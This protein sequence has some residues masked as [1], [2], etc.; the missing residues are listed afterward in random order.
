MAGL[1]PS[2]VMQCAGVLPGL[3]DYLDGDSSTENSSN[4]SDS[5]AD[6]QVRIAAVSVQLWW[7]VYSILFEDHM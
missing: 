1:P 2:Q 3:G 5:E 4:S 6:H 7:F